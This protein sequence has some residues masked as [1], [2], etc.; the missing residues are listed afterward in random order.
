ME[1]GKRLLSIDALRGFD[2]FFISGGG[3]FLVLLD[4]KTGLSWI[5]ALAHQLH[6]VEWNGFVFYDFIFPLFLF[7]AGVSLS[8]S[9]TKGKELGMDKKELYKKV[10]LRMLILIGLGIIYKNHP[11]KFF[12]PSQIRF[13]SVLGR[14]GFAC[15]ITTLLFLNFSLKARLLWIAGIL[16]GYYGLL[17]LVPVP[18]YGPGDLSIEGNII[19]WFDRMFLPGRLHNGGGIYDEN[20]LLTQLSALCITVFGSIAGDVLRM[21]L[22]G[23]RKTLIL[24]GGGLAIMII[25]LIWGLHFPINKKLWSSSFIML[26]S[27]IAFMSMALFYWIIDVKGYTKWAF[28]FKVI[29]MNSLTVYFVYGFVPFEYISAQLFGGLYAPLPE[30]WHEVFAAI[31]GVILVWSFLYFLYKKNIFIKI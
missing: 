18:G 6:H 12:E 24:V 14:I 11:V 29:G 9:L 25:G 26:T 31:G 8:F 4:G 10:F 13:V 15:F 27:G 23:N 7:I 3:T 2:M 20:G 22:T 17:F 28:P 16:V 5:D 21:D 30:E 1:T 19:G